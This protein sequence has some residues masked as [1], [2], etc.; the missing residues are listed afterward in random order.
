MAMTR[1]IL[2]PFSAEF[3]SSNF[4]GLNTVNARPVLAFDASTQE[5]AYWTLVA[6]QGL[7]G[8][9][10][11][12]LTYMMASATSGNIEFEVSAEAITDAD[13][14]DLDATTSFDAVNA[15]GAIA[16][17]GTAGYLDQVSV[18]LTNADSVAA[19]DL[20][21]ISISRDADDGTNDTATGDLYLLMAELR[22]A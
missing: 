16:V 15:S 12:V 22:E 8:A 5:T 2:T 14:T 10:S 20:L 13:A 9:L 7:S 17:P 4:P 11:C 18:T 6:P 3:P 19:G 1:A 21:R